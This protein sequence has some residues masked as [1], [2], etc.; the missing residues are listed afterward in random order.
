MN[1]ANNLKK[2]RINNGLSQ[3]DLSEILDIAPSTVTMYETG[4]REP[5]FTLLDKMATFFNVSTDYLLGRENTQQD[6]HPYDEE[7]FTIIN[8][9]NEIQDELIELKS[10][11][12]QKLNEV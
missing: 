9:I 6:H 4:R 3:K 1:F 5:N 7:L 11:I 10:K 2:L 8:R 12:H